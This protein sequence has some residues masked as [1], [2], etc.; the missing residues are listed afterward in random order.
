MSDSLISLLFTTP[1]V[2]IYALPLLLFSLILTFAGTFLT[3]D[4]SRS[5]P[6]SS[7]V[8]YAALPIP[9]TFSQNKTEHRFI[10]LLEGGVG[11]LLSGYVFGR[12]LIHAFFLDVELM[13]V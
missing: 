12:M 2:L 8:D 1:Y 10:W 5:F 13:D 4:R 3:L 11:G 6:P 9:G 7:E